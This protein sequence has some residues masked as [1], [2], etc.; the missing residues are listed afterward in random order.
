VRDY[1]ASRFRLSD[2]GELERQAFPF[3]TRDIAMPQI[4]QANPAH[5]PRNNEEPGVTQEE[6]IP[7]NGKDK[8]SEELGRDKPGPKL[9]DPRAGKE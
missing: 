3:T 7:S 8:R 4:P 2:S 5:Q 9:S 6:D 1:T